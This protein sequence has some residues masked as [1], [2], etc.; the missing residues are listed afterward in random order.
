MITA[1][2]YVW[3]DPATIPSLA[4]SLEKMVA[5]PIA[6]TARP[7]T[8]RGEPLSEPRLWTGRQ[9]AVTSYGIEALDGT[10]AIAADQ[11]RNGNGTPRTKGTMGRGWICHLIGKDW[12]DMS[13]FIVALLFAEEH[14]K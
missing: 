13:D 2:P 1:T 7:I 3:K 10:Y 12:V 5:R 14:F 6:P 8:L 4:E 11:I 9:W